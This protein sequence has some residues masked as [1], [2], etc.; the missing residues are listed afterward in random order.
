MEETMRIGVKLG[1]VSRNYTKR[2]KE[3]RRS[4]F[5]NKTKQQSDTEEQG[6]HNYRS[7]KLN[8]RD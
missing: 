7:G 1:E 5:K 2:E 4:Q 8:Q 6:R 3:K